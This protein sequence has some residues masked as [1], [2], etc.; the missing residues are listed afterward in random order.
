MK[1]RSFMYKIYPKRIVKK[2]E[3]KKEL[4]SDDQKISVR[5]FLYVRLLGSILVFILFMILSKHSY[6]TAPLFTCL[7]YVSYTYLK[8]D[9]PIKVRKAKLEHEAI[10]FFEILQL[11]LEGGRTLS[12]ALDI[13]SANVDGELSKEFRKTLDE[14]KMGKSLIESL[15]DMKYRIPS[16]EINNTILNITESSIFGSNIISSLNSQLEYLRNKELMEVKSK[17]AKLPVKI[18]VIS[19][20]LFIPLI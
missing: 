7:Y 14:V 16:S 1:K 5:K 8:F 12:Q 3:E 11:T 19:V 6:I 9:Y 20:V 10:F 4:L 17:I 2:L 15:K 13:T 18:S